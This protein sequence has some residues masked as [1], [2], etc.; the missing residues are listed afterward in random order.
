MT[1]LK[2][3]AAVALADETPAVPILDSRELRNTLGLFATGVTVVTA[4]GK[5]GKP[6]GITANS[7][8]SLSLDP[9]LILWSL[10]LK[11]PNLD[12][13]GQGR[14]FVVNIL[15]RQQD[16]LA[17]KFARAADDKFASVSHGVSRAGVPLID[18]SLAQLECR[19]EFTRIAGDHLLIVGRVEA[20][21][22]R[23]GDPLLFYRG[24]FGQLCA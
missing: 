23:E 15:D 1:T 19:V 10:A 20:F 3:P 8:S 17:M 24:A 14:P 9:P 22:T 5:D 6:I 2:T 18:E 4:Q 7:F 12:A 16:A 11:S 13:F 21:N